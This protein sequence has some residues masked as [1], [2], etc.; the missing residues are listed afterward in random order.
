M[1]ISETEP[2]INYSRGKRELQV[3]AIKAMREI[4]PIRGRMAP[5]A[6][7]AFDV[8]CL[9][10]PPRSS[11]NM[12]RKHIFHRLACAAGALLTLAGL[13]A[14]QTAS[15]LKAENAPLVVTRGQVSGTRQCHEYPAHLAGQRRSGRSRGGV[16]ARGAD[17]RKSGGR[18]LAHHLAA[19]RTAVVVRPGGAGQQ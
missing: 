3:G 8:T 13:P 1:T 18:D 5:F 10:S 11:C 14:T 19:G 16:S 9:A 4:G 2:T 15:E 6:R 7:S 12:S 17:H